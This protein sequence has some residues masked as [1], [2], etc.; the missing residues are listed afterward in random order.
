MIAMAEPRTST[1]LSEVFYALV[2]WLRD[3][4]VHVYVSAGAETAALQ[5]QVV[6]LTAAL[7]KCEK[8]RLRLQNLYTSECLVNLSL[9]DRLRESSC[10]R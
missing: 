5:A 3:P 8:E 1:L 9:E 2:H 10:R 6:D 4:A 7:E